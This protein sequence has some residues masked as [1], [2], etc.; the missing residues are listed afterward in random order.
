MAIKIKKYPKA[1]GGSVYR[2][3]PGSDYVNREEMYQLIRQE[4]AIY[5]NSDAGEEYL[6]CLQHAEERSTVCEAL[7]Y[8]V[9]RAGGF[10]AYIEALERHPG[11][12]LS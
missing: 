1:C 9:I 12:M 2:I 3:S 10:M 4:D 7:L 8:R 5:V 11:V 6:K